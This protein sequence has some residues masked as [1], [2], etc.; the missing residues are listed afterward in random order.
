MIR[1]LLAMTLLTTSLGAFVQAVDAGE[2]RLSWQ[3]RYLEISGDELP[4]DVIRIHYLEAYCRPG[5]TDQEW[6][7]TVI[8]HE[9]QL[10]DQADDGKR[11]KIRDRLADGVVVEHLIE[12]AGQEVSFTVTATNPTDQPSLAHWAQPCMRVDKFTGTDP[13]DSRLTEPPYI[14]KCFLMVDGKLTRLPTKPWALQARY[15]PGQ[16]YAPASVDRNDVNPRPLSSV[17]PSSGL[18]GCY[19]ADEQTLL[20]IAWRPYQE[21]FQGVITC[22]HSDFRIGGLKPGESKTIHGKLYVLPSDEGELLKRY[23]RDFP[24]ES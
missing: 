9:S 3:K 20:A 8:P 17:I 24:A 4:G 13:K 16:V 10:V 18:T 12:A 1:C 22:M 19:S 15:V 21:V 14:K 23:Q 7:K 2:L 11:I 6:G 5:S